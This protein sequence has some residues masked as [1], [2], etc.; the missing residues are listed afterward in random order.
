MKLNLPPPLFPLLSLPLSG[1]VLIGYSPGTE[2]MRR[3]TY[4]KSG[5]CV[6]LHVMFWFDRE[7]TRR[8]DV[9]VGGSYEKRTHTILHRCY[10]MRI[11]LKQSGQMRVWM[12]EWVWMFSV[13]S[14]S[15]DVKNVW[16][17]TGMGKQSHGN[18]GMG[19]MTQREGGTQQ[20]KYCNF[21]FK[22]KDTTFGPYS[23]QLW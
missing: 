21:I 16:R 10:I 3:L 15:A 5:A 7:V 14:S 9:G 22:G 2:L 13:E 1:S 4:Y 19:K 6:C 18:E 12:S 8:T 23:Y 11:S 20:V 17:R